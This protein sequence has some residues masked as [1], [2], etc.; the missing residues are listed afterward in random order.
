[1]SGTDLSGLPAHPGAG[2][3]RA[4]IYVRDISGPH[5]RRRW[6]SIWLTQLVYF[7]L[8]WLRWNGRPAVLFDLDAA[9]FH[10][11]GLTLLPHDLVYL[12]GLLM[13]C[14]GLLFLLSAVAGRVWCRFGCPHTVYAELFGWIERAVEGKR[15]ARIRLDQQAGSPAKYAKKTV[16]HAAWMALSA[17]I[18]VTLAAYFTPLPQL[19]RALGDLALGPWQTFW[20][21]CYGG[22]A[23]LNAGWMRERFC[24]Y[25]CA[26]ARFQSVMFDRDTFVVAYDAMRGEPRGARRSW[27][28]GGSAGLGGC[29]DCTLCVQVCPT[30]IDI[31]NGLQFECIDCAA[32]IDACD[33]VMDK[34]G[35]ARGLIRYDTQRAAEGGRS[36]PP[37]RRIVARPRVLGYV[38]VL[39][40]GMALYASMLAARAP[41]KLGVAL[42]RAA[43]G[44]QEEAGAIDRVYR[45][46]ITNSDARPHR[47]MVGL[48]GIDGAL[49]AEDIVVAVPGAASRIV[50]VR[51]RVTEQGRAP[52]QAARE[53][54]REAGREAAR[55]ASR[56]FRFR[57]V[58]IDDQSIRASADA[59]FPERSASPYRRTLR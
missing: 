13:L 46:H 45:L 22:L 59:A 40:C 23:Y 33:G 8:P 38:A 57:L 6:Q 41:L 32:C 48:D 7:G 29:I 5:T 56:R 49:V 21:V 36:A 51:V 31:R 12:A 24:K 25:I 10:L 39:A 20:I 4:K 50:P 55:P 30:G 44:P 26:Y 9:T 1:V 54:G 37:V 43:I 28:A 3:A 18:G 11:F 2:K 35:A 34:I 52:E 53:A 19:L 27:R 47:Y 58:A 17:W 14:A 16:K 42:D 15:S